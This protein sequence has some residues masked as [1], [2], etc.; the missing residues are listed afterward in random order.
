M[1]IDTTCPPTFAVTFWIADPLP[2]KV[3]AP[4]KLTIFGWRPTWMS[5]SS[6]LIS[7]IRCCLS[8]LSVKEDVVWKLTLWYNKTIVIFNEDANVMK[9]FTEGSSEKYLVPFCSRS[10]LSPKGMYDVLITQSLDGKFKL[11][12]CKSQILKI[13]PIFLRFQFCH[14]L[15]S[16]ISCPLPSLA[17]QFKVDCC[18]HVCCDSFSDL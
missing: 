1:F 16:L 17:W 6:S 4:T 18:Q 10:F 3:Q 2:S 15:S 8:L 7:A 9:W 12:R 11:A 5:V 13:S 14:S